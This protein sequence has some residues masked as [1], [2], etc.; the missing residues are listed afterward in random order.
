M[1]TH[2]TPI[3]PHHLTW[4]TSASPASRGRLPGGSQ[5][6]VAPRLH[7]SF[8]MLLLSF[9]TRLSPYVAATIVYFGSENRLSP[10]DLGEGSGRKLEMVNTK[11]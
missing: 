6:S 7:R 10:V 8:K 11:D 4:F 1:A 5:S 3:E 2:T 9:Q